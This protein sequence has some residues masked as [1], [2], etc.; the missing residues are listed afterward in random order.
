[1]W[2]LGSKG[3]DQESEGGIWDQ[4]PGIRDYKPWDRDQQLSEG[5]GIRD[6]AVPLLWVRKQK[7]L[8]SWNQGSEIWIQKWGQR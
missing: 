6:Q 2:D 7:L 4:S 3:W 5:S 8:R 1:M